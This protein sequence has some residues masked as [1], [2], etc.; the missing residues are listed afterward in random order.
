MTAQE[1]WRHLKD[2]GGYSSPER[3]SRFLPT[4]RYY[5]GGIGVVIRAR[6]R[7]LLSR[8]DRRAFEQ[9]SFQSMRLIEKCGGRIEIS[10]MEHVAA[11]EGPVVFVSNHMSMLETF[12]LPGLILPFK[13]VTF[14]IKQDLLRYP[15]FGPVLSILQVIA[16][17]RRN[18]RE[19]F[20][21]VLDKGVAC[22]R[23]G[24]SVVVFPQSTRSV[25]FRPAFFNT[26]GVK[27]AAKADVPVIPVALRTDLQ[28]NGRML[29]DF[30]PIHPERTVHFC[31]G[32][33]LRIEGHGKAQHEQVV[34]FISG[35]MQAWGVR[36]REAEG[37]PAADPPV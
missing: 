23:S 4:A 18:P 30:G 10:G 31:F 6:L 11:I 27:L 9:S 36:V 29:K 8:Y 35:R 26:L 32:P 17:T 24:V 2:A 21:E 12:V 37:E 28:S 34:Q 19:D 3:R 7:V 1:F 14:V 20:R 13:P 15:L 16:V 22:L 5:A 25:D 33:A